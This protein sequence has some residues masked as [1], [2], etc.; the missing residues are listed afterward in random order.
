VGAAARGPG[1]VNPA[2]S[3]VERVRRGTAECDRSI[4]SASPH[5]IEHLLE[6]L[7]L[8]FVPHAAAD[9][10]TLPWPGTQSSGNDRRHVVAAV[11]AGQASVNADAVLSEPG[12]SNLDCIGQ[13]GC[14]L[15]GL[16]D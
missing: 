16:T 6:Q 1:D 9:D 7:K 13:D 4:G 3:C 12:Y 8:I 14:A 5:Q 10:A 11:Q 2:G 15:A